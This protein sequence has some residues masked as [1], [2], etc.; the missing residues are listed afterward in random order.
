MGFENQNVVSNTG[1]N[2][3]GVLTVI[4]KSKICVNEVIK[5]T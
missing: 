3:L 4:F 1:Y 2:R 5:S